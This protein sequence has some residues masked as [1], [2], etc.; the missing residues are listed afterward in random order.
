MW[1]SENFGHFWYTV[2]SQSDPQIPQVGNTDR[3]VKYDDYR[4]R[5]LA[6]R[7]LNENELYVLCDGSI[8]RFTR[9][10]GGPT[11]WDR[12]VVTD[13][14]NKCFTYKESDIDG[15]Q[16]DYLP[17]LGDWSDLAFHVPGADGKNDVVRRMRRSQLDAEDGHAVVVRRQGQVARDRVCAAP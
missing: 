3:D 12:A 4:D 16:M 5:V 8:Q 14:K 15:A 11:L 6:C 17:P 1:V 13:H 10:P 2:T 7:W 9:K